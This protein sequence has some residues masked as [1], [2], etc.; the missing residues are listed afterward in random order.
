MKKLV[1]PALLFAGYA[2]S[3]QKCND[4]FFL[5]N[6]KT[7]EM[8]ITTKKGKEGGKLVYAISHV[9]KS[10]SVTTSIANS[11]FF[12]KNGKTISKSVNAIQC[13]G[14]TFMVDMKA[15]IPSAQQEQ[16]GDISGST[17]KVYLEYPANMKEGDALKDGSFSMDF[18]A[19]SGLASHVEV[20]L[21]NRKV[22]GKESVTTPAGTWD[23]FK[24][25][26]HSKVVI[27]MGIGIPFNTDITEWYAPGFGVVKSESEKGGMTEITA[28]K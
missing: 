7:V 25:T 16:M 9:K 19:K 20:S 10:G 4:Y 28:I 14:G 27:K 24:I 11:E 22:A 6:N 23:C 21:T 3:S 26:Y 2:A 12:D 8:T 5:Q 17:D 15:F 13:D 18:K 1:L